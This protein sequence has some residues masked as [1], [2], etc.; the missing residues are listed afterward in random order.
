MYDHDIIII[1][2]LVWPD[3]LCAGTYRLEIIRSH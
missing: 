1:I 2:G 3:T